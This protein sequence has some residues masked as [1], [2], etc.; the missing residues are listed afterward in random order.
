MNKQTNKKIYYAVINNN[1]I[2]IYY[3]IFTSFGQM[4]Y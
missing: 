3:E 4:L 2:T 1:I